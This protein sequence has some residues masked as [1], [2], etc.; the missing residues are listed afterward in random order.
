MIWRRW[1]ASAMKL[2]HERHNDLHFVIPAANAQRHQQIQSVL[3]HTDLPVSLVNGQGREVM[4]SSDAILI[5]SGTAT[6]EAMLMRKPMVI[7]YRMGAISWRILSRMV[8]TPHVGL[9]NI[10]AG[11]A[12]VPELLQQQATSLALAD[13]VTRI[14]E[15]GGAHQVRR[16]DELA[17]LIGGDFAERSIDALQPLVE[18]R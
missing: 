5:A 2:L 1:F 6:L 14:L 12:V 3:R 16:F 4:Q 18:G 8:K 9:P 13:A 11:E 10:L 7:S 17:G 15:G